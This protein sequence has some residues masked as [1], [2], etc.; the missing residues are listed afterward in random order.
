MNSLVEAIGARARSIALNS[1]LGVEKALEIS[2]DEVA[3]HSAIFA[4]ASVATEVRQALA[5]YGSLTQFI[6]DP[7]VEEIWMN[8]PNE[9]FAFRSGSVERHVV[10]L[11]AEEQRIII[12]RMLR[13]AGRR[14]DRTS[15]FADASLPDGSRLHVVIPDITRE[16]LSFNLRKFSKSEANRTINEGQ[17]RLI[18]QALESK[19]SVL[20]SGATAAGK[21]T[22]LNAILN[23][24]P[25]SDRVV[26]VEDTLELAFADRDA[27][28]MQTRPASIEGGGEIDL[29]RLV[30]ESLRMRPTWLVVG[31]V[32]GGEAAE[33]LI[34]LNS[35]LPALCT[36]HANSADQALTKLVTLPM[37]AHSNVDPRFVTEV[38]RNCI[39]LVVHCTQS[40]AGVRTVAE[41]KVLAD[42]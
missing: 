42:A 35:G 34:A 28:A 6:E 20:I 23:S 11:D 16:H 25:K 12:D 8:R 36:I 14:I 19:K 3:E 2:L 4:E 10:R 1:G 27:V 18:L 7:E 21:T 24:L 39:G 15:P 30:R 40:D 13:S 37:L 9:L 26:S 31:E 22:L 41:V 5:G 32:R 33:L 29:R 38:V 17:H